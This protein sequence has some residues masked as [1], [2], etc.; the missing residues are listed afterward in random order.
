ME[1]P[2]IGSSCLQ[3]AEK[4]KFIHV[5]DYMISLREGKTGMRMYVS[6]PHRAMG[7]SLN[8]YDTRKKT[9]KLETASQ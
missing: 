8:K 1:L 6:S 2:H 4:A 7:H 3:A 9:K 5:T